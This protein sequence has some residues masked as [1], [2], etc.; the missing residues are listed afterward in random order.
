MFYDRRMPDAA[1]LAPPPPPFAPPPPFWE[2]DEAEP[3]LR[4]AMEAG[5]SAALEELVDAVPSGEMARVLSH[6]D[7]GEHERLLTLLGPEAAGALVEEL[8]DEQAADLL[9][10]LEPNAAAAILDEVASHQQADVLEQF[11]EAEAEAI[12]A[13]M[14]PEEAADVRL[15]QQYPPDSAGG[16]MITEYLSFFERM[17]VD[18]V[19]ADLRTNAER[20]R[21]YDVQYAYVIDSHGVLR[22]VLR[23]RDL[24]LSPRGV[25]VGEIMIR[26]PERVRCSDMLDALEEFF[27]VHYYFAVPVV[28][29]SDG[30]LKGVV[31][32]AHVEEALGERN[33]R[34]IL[35]LGGIIGGEELRTAP[36]LTRGVRRLAFLTP[37]ILLNLISASVVA[38]F[39]GTIEALPYL[40]IFLPI[41]SDMSGCSGNQ[42]VAVSIRELSMGLVRPGDVWRVVMKEVSVGLLNGVVLGLLLAGVGWLYFVLTQ[43]GPASSGAMLGVVVGLALMFNTVLAVSIGGSVPLVLKG[44]KVDPAMAAGPI[45]TTIT[46][47]C[48][49]FFALG[50]ATW[51]LVG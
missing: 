41:L 36:T 46:D 11:D 17:T 18:D 2:E 26:D 45:L 24:V 1:T 15:L 51:L 49:F 20:Y 22:G 14:D 3:R 9:E 23:L 34:T 19:L 28:D 44:L 16:L 35:K 48:G 7:A 38:V 29:A 25:A 37:N 4:A 10:E 27:D 42:A 31:R 8:S 50:L 5:D 33:Q 13:L 12:I 43:E 30:T 32:R 40:A 21:E 39:V 47:L 6:L